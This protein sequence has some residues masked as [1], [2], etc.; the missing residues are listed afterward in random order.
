MPSKKPQLLLIGSRVPYPLTS[1]ERHQGFH[2]AQRLSHHFDLHLIYLAAQ[3][4]NADAEREL[5]PFAK[6]LRIF[7]VSPWAQRIHALRALFGKEPLQVAYCFF[8][9]IQQEVDR[10][11]PTMDVAVCNLIRTARYLKGRPIP[12]VL[13]ISDSI[14]LNYRNSI[15]Q[16]S[17]PLWRAIYRIES[18]RLLAYEQDCVADFGRTLFFNAEEMAF[19][20][21]PDRTRW[22]PFGA[23]GPLLSRPL[24]KM[25]SN[26]IAF[27]GKMDY[28][29]NVDAV[30][31][32]CQ[33]VLPLLSRDLTFWVVGAQ[34]SESILALPKKH[35]NVQV[36]GFMDDPYSLLGE[37]AAMVA[38][39]Q[40]GAGIQTKI[41]EAMAMGLPVVATSRA[42]K[43]IT[44]AK[45][46]RQIWVADSPEEIATAIRSLLA[47]SDCR[48]AMG[49]EARSLIASTFT[50]DAYEE[51][52][53]GSI[54]EAMHAPTQ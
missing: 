13:H 28:Q 3:Q 23:G 20:G 24:P 14:G 9:E 54:R 43:P 44:G 49:S 42:A 5:A 47:D 45:P 18:T 48:S 11:L 41:L 2:L 37:C 21:R 10:L 38:P 50:W 46:G 15:T 7:P 40:T 36:T 6:S 26:A 22:V 33:H 16:T 27:L 51:A 25:E 30:L 12:R 4:H 32:F 19:F 53:V 17:S 8:D 29:P 52:V 34:P 35:P 1:G 39:M 31:W